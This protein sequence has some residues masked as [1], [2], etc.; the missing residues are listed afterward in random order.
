MA[1]NI[2]RIYS[3]DDFTENS[4]KVDTYF[5]AVDAVHSK[6]VYTKGLTYFYDDPLGVGEENVCGDPLGVGEENVCGGDIS[7]PQTLYVTASGIRLYEL[8]D[9]LV[10]VK[11]TENALVPPIPVPIITVNGDNPHYI[12]LGDSYQDAGASCVDDIDGSRDQTSVLRENVDPDNVG[13]YQV[14]YDCLSGTPYAVEITRVVFVTT[15]PE[16]TLIGANPQTVPLTG[17]LDSTSYV[18]LGATCTDAFGVDISDQVIIGG[19]IVDTSRFGDYTVTYRCQDAYGNNVEQINRTV[20]VEVP[21]IP[22][23]NLPTATFSL[24]GTT[25]INTEVFQPYTDPGATCWDN[26]DTTI[27]YNV[28][29][30]ENTVDVNTLGSYFVT[31]ECEDDAQTFLLELSRHVNVVDTT[32]PVITVSGPDPLTLTLNTSYVEP[33]VTC[34][35]NYDGDISENIILSGDLDMTKVDRYLVIY[36][37]TDSSGNLSAQKSR[38]VFV[39]ASAPPTTDTTPPEITLI[40]KHPLT[41]PIGTPYVDAGATCEDDV[42]GDISEQIVIGGDTVDTSTLGDYTVTYDCADSSGN[43][44]E[45]EY[46]DVEVEDPNVGVPPTLIL[47]GANPQSINLDGTYTEFGAICID[48]AKRDISDIIDIEH[49]IETD[50]PGNYDVTYQ[51]EDDTNQTQAERTRQVIVLPAV[52][53]NDY[54]LLT[55]I[56]DNPQSIPLN[57]KYTE[58]GAICIDVED[59]DLFVRISSWDVR[60]IDTNTPGLYTVSYNCIDEAG[61]NVSATRAV[62]VT[63]EPA[64]ATIDDT[65]KKKRGGGGC[66]GDCTPPTFFKTKFNLPVVENGFSFDGVS[67]DVTNYHTEYPLITV[68]TQQTYNMKLKVYESNNLKWFQIA[69][70]MPEVGIPFNYAESVATFYLNYDGTLDRVE[71]VDKHTLIDIINSEV[72]RVD[73]GYTESMCYELSVDFVYRDQQKNN[74]VA[75]QAVDM[76][77]NSVTHFMN[78]GILVVG[79]SMNVPLETTVGAGK[80][81]AFYP[82]RSGLVTLTLVDYKTDSWQDEYGYLWTS[83]NYKSFTLLDTI[84]KPIKEPDVMWAAMTRMNSNFADMIIHEQDRAVLVFDG[85]KLLNTLPGSWTYELPNHI[86]KAAELEERKILE[87]Y[88][89]QL[90][91]DELLSKTHRAHMVN[92]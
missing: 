81:G 33:G 49:V 30:E 76:A 63:N 79:E 11:S 73:C 14:L 35:D 62:F 89:S 15:P 31:Y 67:T 71:K 66:S 7:I 52:P 86:Q 18:E 57:G 23:P 6:Y 37:C 24:N 46:R 42:D 21:T 26:V 43:E 19:E 50:R 74:V 32:K 65:P 45:Q 48:S 41:I 87:V 39:V 25:V 78:D 80:A 44:A 28:S 56:G 58:L 38:E 90:I 61:E 75:I 10:D 27:R 84:P 70:G 2:Y 59:G 91:L 82:Q 8:P 68:N 9:C 20:T 83:D 47:L 69:F 5:Y 54:P 92:D 60:N 17:F 85:S 88:K 34:E 1:K 64:P 40:G 3:L 72:S 16:M 4:F 53:V 77:R 22:G 36:E 29:L 55:L 51:C 12:G 13:R